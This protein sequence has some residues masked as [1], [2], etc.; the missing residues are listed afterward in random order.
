MQSHE[1]PEHRWLRTF[2]GTWDYESVC[3]MGPGQPPMKASG[4][5]VVRALGDLWVVGESQGT[6][7]GG[8][9]MQAIITMGFDPSRGARG[10]FVGTWIGSPMTTMFVYEGQIEGSLDAPAVALPLRCTGPSFADPT[11]TTTYIDTVTLHADGRRTLTSKAQM[12]DGSWV[13]FMRAEYRKV[14]G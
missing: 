12:E 2:V 8:G 1:T 3:E 4:R 13:E 14:K 11:K 10:A 7:P 5:E 9:T 6:M